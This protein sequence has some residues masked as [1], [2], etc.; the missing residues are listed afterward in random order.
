[1]LSF[2]HGPLGQTLPE[3]LC[4]DSARLRGLCGSGLRPGSPCR[5]RPHTRGS[6]LQAYPISCSTAV[7]APTGRGTLCLE[8]ALTSCRLQGDLM[9][10]VLCARSLSPRYICAQGFSQPWHASCPLQ[11]AATLYRTREARR[12]GQTARLPTADGCPPVS[13]GSNAMTT[14]RVGCISALGHAGGPILSGLPC[15]DVHTWRDRGLCTAYHHGTSSGQPA[16]WCATA[17][18]SSRAGR[19]GCATAQRCATPQVVDTL[20]H[21]GGVAHAMPCRTF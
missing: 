18:D 4:K 16:V 1:M 21:L 19:Q 14:R 10:F 20:M 12:G 13:S 17:R 3:V 15:V 11:R 9:A 8:A 7:Y 6:P 2:T 5:C